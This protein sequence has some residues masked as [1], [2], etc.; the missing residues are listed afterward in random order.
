[1][2][3][4]Y[5]TATAAAVIDD[6]FGTAARTAPTTPMKLSVETV[7][8]T[9]AAAGTELAS[10]TRPTIAFGS[11]TG[12]PPVASSTGT[13]TVTAGSAGTVVSIAIYDSAATPVRKAF[14]PLASSRTVASGDSLAFA[15]GSITFTLSSP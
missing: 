10:T 3:S 5:T 14:G 12:T 4:G 9:A 7:A 2:A 15:A 1:M 13:T 6:Q 11:A 8:G